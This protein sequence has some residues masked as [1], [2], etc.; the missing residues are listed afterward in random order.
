MP[1]SIVPSE[2]YRELFENS[3]DAVLLT[4]PDGRI[5]A[6]NPAACAMFGMTEDELC[7][8]GR[9]ALLDTADAG[10]SLFLEERKQLGKARGELTCRRKDGSTFIGDI[11]SVMLGQGDRAFVIIRDIT[12]RKRAEEALRESEELVRTIAE[13]ST[14]AL[15]MMDERGFCTYANPALLAMT[16]YTAEEIHSRPLHDL[17]HHHYPDGRPYPLEECPLDRALPENSDVR[18]HRDLFFRK[19]GTAFPVLCAASPVF[20][21]GRPVA[22]VIE[23]RDITEPERAEE[24]LHRTAERY[25]QQMRLFD[26]VAATTPDFVYVFDLQGRFLYA[27][28]QLLEVWGMELPDVIG[29]TCR[30]LGYEQWHHDMHMRE[31]AQVIE[32]KRP[33][34]GEVPFKAPRTGVFGV[35][36]YIFTPVMGPDDEV[37][38]IAGTTRDITEHKRFEDVLKEAKTAAEEASRAKSEFLANMSHEIR[39]PMTVFMAAIEHLLQID[40]DPQRRHVLG[41]ADQSAKRLRTLIDDILDLSRIESGKIEIEEASFDLRACVGETVEMFALQAREKKLRIELEVSA[42]V[43]PRVVGDVGRLGQVLINLVGN[44]VKFTPAGEIRVRVQPQGDRLVF[45]VADTGIGIPEEKRALLFQNFTQVDS[46]FTRKYGGSGLGLAISRGL[47]EL[48]GGEISVSSREGKGSVF[49]FAVPLKSAGRQSSPPAEHPV[50]NN[51]KVSLLQ[52]SWI[53][54]NTS[55]PGGVGG[56]IFGNMPSDRNPEGQFP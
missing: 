42:E 19:D 51:G 39:T 21:A 48:M 38:L 22:T 15:V 26:G 8:V 30:E 32:T 18:A 55:M 37:E 44:A 25:Q 20:K 33:I 16:G 43:P 28:N 56:P 27:N 2:A 12:E 35:Y 53:S 34:K 23:V 52:K 45:S 29:K 46:S 36:E 31:I 47:V 13:N 5:V 7:A 14:Q 54:E 50:K 10:Y 41:M 6:A 11:S 49:T 40:D 1:S 24:E 9:D 17:V 3:L 4:I